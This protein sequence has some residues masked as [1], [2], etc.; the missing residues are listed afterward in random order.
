VHGKAS[1]WRWNHPPKPGPHLHCTRMKIVWAAAGLP[2]G[3]SEW[4][5][6]KRYG[7]KWRKG[8]FLGIHVTDSSARYTHG[9]QY[10]RVLLSA[11]ATN[12]GGTK[13][14]T[15]SAYLKAE[16]EFEISTENNLSRL[17]NAAN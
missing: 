8:R 9:I 5:G 7:V 3:P 12:T 2:W 13:T 11:A 1:N 14:V 17:R 16:Y 6:T 15:R 4:G 10:F